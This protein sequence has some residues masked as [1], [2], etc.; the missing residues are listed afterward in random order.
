[1]LVTPLLEALLLGADLATPAQGSVP[2]P[3]ALAELSASTEIL[4]PPL[5]FLVRPV[6]MGA[7]LV[8]PGPRARRARP[9]R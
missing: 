6:T 9:G 3:W 7:G 2:G 8:E 5:S 4:L 1:M